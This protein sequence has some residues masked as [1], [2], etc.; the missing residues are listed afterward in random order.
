MIMQDGQFDAALRYCDQVGLGVSESRKRS[1]QELL[2]DNM[3]DMYARSHPRTP[4]EKDYWLAPA[5]YQ[6]ATWV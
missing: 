1:E 2:D 5:G 3:E 6:L 4:R